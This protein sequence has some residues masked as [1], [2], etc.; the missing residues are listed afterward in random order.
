[1]T[2]KIHLSLVTMKVSKRKNS[3]LPVS[4]CNIVY[5]ERRKRCTLEI[6]SFAA[7]LLIVSCAVELFIG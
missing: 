2:E 1:M 7:S 6:V 5:C 4:V 3:I